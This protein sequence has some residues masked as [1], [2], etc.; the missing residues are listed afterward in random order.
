[1]TRNTTRYVVPGT[2]TF[3][4]ASQQLFRNM[5]FRCG[6][7]LQNIEKSMRR[8][9]IPDEGKIFVQVD[10]SGAEALIVSYL[11]RHGKFR[12]LFL[13]KVKPHVFVAMHVFAKELQQCMNEGALDIKFDID[14]LLRSEIKDL[15]KHPQWNELDT[16]IK[17]TDNWP[18]EKRYYYMGKQ[19]CHSSN[20]DVTAGAFSLNVLIKSKGRIVLQKREAERLLSVYFTLFPEIR[21]W[22][23]EVR[24]QLTDTRYLFNLFGYP[25]Y[26]FFPGNPHDNDF[27]TA[28]AWVPQSTV[29]TI[30]NIACAKLQDYIEVNALNWDILANTHDSYMVQ[31]P[32]DETLECAKVMTAF[33]NQ[34]LTSPSGEVFRMKSEAQAGF[35]WAPHKK[36]T[37][38][39][40][41][42]ELKNL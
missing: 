18:A 4:L 40:G 10:Q 34:E 23:A 11:C 39:T 15:K 36:V 16:L 37:N 3:R 22:H 24:K 2:D 41:L 31:C 14:E 17:S 42:M 9:Y 12:D 1:M 8:L 5:K 38:E 20:Y 29:G 27:K 25:R 6:A 32:M 21:D 35:N 33:M 7:N 26:F 30:T 19:V 13:N 28:Y